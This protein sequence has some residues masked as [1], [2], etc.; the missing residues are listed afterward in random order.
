MPDQ[1][2]SLTIL[3]E[4]FQKDEIIDREDS[5]RLETIIREKWADEVY[6]EQENNAILNGI[7]FLQS[8]KDSSLWI[9]VGDDLDHH[10]SMNDIR[11][12]LAH[13]ENDKL[14]TGI[15]EAVVDAKMEKIVA[16]EF[17]KTSRGEVQR[18]A[19]RPALRT[20]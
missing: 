9:D 8:F 11:W 5:T 17:L 20:F 15:V 13:L 18:G 12:N 6:T 14:A 1:L 16:W 3:A 19:R 4:N 10:H 2:D 7:A